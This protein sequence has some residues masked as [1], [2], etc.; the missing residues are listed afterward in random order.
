MNWE[1]IIKFLNDE[2]E[3]DK[4]TYFGYTFMYS[5]SR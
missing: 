2:E 4:S 5:K 1:I 3:I